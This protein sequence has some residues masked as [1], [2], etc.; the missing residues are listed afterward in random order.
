MYVTILEKAKYRLQQKSRPDST[1]RFSFV[2]FNRHFTEQ[3]SSF[4]LS[5]PHSRFVEGDKH[6]ICDYS[7]ASFEGCGLTLK[8]QAENLDLIEGET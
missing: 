4:I 2:A 8:D 7:F 1:I 3:K 6:F 5:T